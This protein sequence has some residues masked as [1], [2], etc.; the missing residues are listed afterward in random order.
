MPAKYNISIIPIIIT[1]WLISSIHELVSL[2][3]QSNTYRMLA[4]PTETVSK[5]T[6]IGYGGGLGAQANT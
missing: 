6:P 4:A 5:R 1:T 2:F 3:S